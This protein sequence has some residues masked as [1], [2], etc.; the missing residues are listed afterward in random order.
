[1]RAARGTGAS[2]AGGWG[3]RPGAGSGVVTLCA[4]CTLLRPKLLRP[5]TTRC[6]DSASMQQ[7]QGP[8]RAWWAPAPLHQPPAAPARRSQTSAAQHEVQRRPWGCCSPGYPYSARLAYPSAL[9]A[10][11][12][13]GEKG[14]RAKTG[15][16]QL[17][18]QVRAS[19]GSAVRG[20]DKLRRTWSVAG[21][22]ITSGDVELETTSHLETQRSPQWRSPQWRVDAAMSIATT[23]GQL[24]PTRTEGTVGHVGHVQHRSVNDGRQSAISR[25][26]VY[27]PRGAAHQT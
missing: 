7:H 15:Q 10:Q 17:P 2:A 6:S 3:G 12:A 9:H 22:S 18:E 27:H 8:G 23:V 1:M 19:A 5:H 21:T 11:Q 24:H 20:A 25:G 26:S 13:A 14:K 16:M 4:N